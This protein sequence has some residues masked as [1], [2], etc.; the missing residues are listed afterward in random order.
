M[1]IRSFFLLLWPLT[2]SPPPPPPPFSAISKVNTPLNAGLTHFHGGWLCFQFSH[3]LNLPST[4]EEK[5]K[6][7]VR[8]TKASPKRTRRSLSEAALKGQKCDAAAA[9]LKGYRCFLFCL[10]ERGS[11]LRALQRHRRAH[12]NTRK[13]VT[14][15]TRGREGWKA[16][17]RTRTFSL[18]RLLNTP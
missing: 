17:P 15:A 13:P 2:P 7:I 14:P 10:G 16:C 5:G 11:A 6:T 18:T 8:T 1:N 4:L 9:C 12:N 3:H